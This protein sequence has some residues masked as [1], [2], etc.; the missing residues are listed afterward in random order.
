[1]QSAAETPER[2]TARR[3][4]NFGTVRIFAVSAI[5]EAPCHAATLPT[6]QIGQGRRFND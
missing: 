3:D 2:V 5:V 4:T 6:A 1:M